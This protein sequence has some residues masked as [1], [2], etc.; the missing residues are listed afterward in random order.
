MTKV[1]KGEFKIVH[2]A[3]LLFSIGFVAVF[4]VF[5]GIA[6]FRKLYEKIRDRNQSNNLY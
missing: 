5:V 1:I 4:L 3:F 6:G 2:P